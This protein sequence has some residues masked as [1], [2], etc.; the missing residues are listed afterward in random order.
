MGLKYVIT[1]RTFGFDP[2]KTE[3]YVPR[4]VTMGEVS[5]EKLCQNVTLIC[6]AHRGVVQ[7]V[8]AGL[9]DAMVRDLDDGKSVRLGE[10]GIFRPGVR[11]HSA[12][13][14]EEVSAENIYRKHI[15]F[16]P[17]KLFKRTLKEISVTRYQQPDTDYTDGSRS[18]DSG[19]GGN[20]GDNGG[21]GN[22][23]NDEDGMLG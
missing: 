21:G 23:G 10:F 15:L 20:G 9:V 6:G 4:S 12:D 2:E 22:D 11:A 3:K 8:I 7:Q 13:S 17:G 14:E 18:N 1:K 5:F 19:N 16:T